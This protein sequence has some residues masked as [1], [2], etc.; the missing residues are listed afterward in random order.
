MNRKKS[1]IV[2]SMIAACFVW[3]ALLAAPAAFAQGGGRAGGAAIGGGAGRGG[4][5]AIGGGA[6][7]GGMIGGSH[8]HS[9][10]HRHGF[11][12]KGFHG[13]S[14]FRH[15]NTFFFGVGAFY[16][17]W[18]WYS[19]YYYWNPPPAYYY[20]YYYPAYSGYP[21]YD[22]YGYPYY[23][24]YGSPYWSDPCL[25]PDP[26]YAEYCPPPPS[27]SQGEYETAPVSGAS[28]D[29]PAQPSGQDQLRPTYPGAGQ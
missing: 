6:R 2:S 22:Y 18:W 9:F 11:H 29:A 21:A 24:Y 5:V 26:A 25:S 20:P 7:G 23:D 8:R 10:G 12:H 14:K 1:A 3:L 16:P 15:K 28:P 17:G 19:P 13:H 4:G 27:P